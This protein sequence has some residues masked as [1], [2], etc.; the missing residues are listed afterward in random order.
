M[1]SCV[2]P[3]LLHKFLMNKHRDKERNIYLC[4]WWCVNLNLELELS[5]HL[6][7]AI[8]AASHPDPAD[9]SRK[10]TSACS[11]FPEQLL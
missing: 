1:R 3:E 7:S 8:E 6:C 11:D 9:V 10:D 5:L 4:V 2:N